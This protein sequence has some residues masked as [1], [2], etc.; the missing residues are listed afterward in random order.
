[1]KTT[2]ITPQD[3]AIIDAAVNSIG[4]RCS[5]L[6][7]GGDIGENTARIMALLDVIAG[8]LATAPTTDGR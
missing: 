6:S 4:E 8:V 7:F 1:M 2:T 3:R 5:S